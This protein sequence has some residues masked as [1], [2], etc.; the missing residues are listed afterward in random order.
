MQAVVSLLDEPHQAMIEHIQSRLE[1]VLGMPGLC[2]T[3]IAHFS[4]HVADEYDLEILAATLLSFA[5]SNTRL[6]VRTSGFGIF[7]SDHPVLYIPVVRTPPLSAQHQALWRQLGRASANPSPLYHPDR[8]MPHITVADRQDL[9]EYL[10][11]ITRLLTGLNLS[12]EI[13]VTNV[14]LLYGEGQA[15]EIGL[16]HELAAGDRTRG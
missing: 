4:Y 10:P 6:Q 12:W 3:P 14:A 1:D 8:W 5:A 16:R 15:L 7:T 9:A 11:D 13:E 2:R